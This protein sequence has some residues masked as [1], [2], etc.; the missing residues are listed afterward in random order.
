MPDHHNYPGW[1]GYDMHADMELKKHGNAVF[2]LL[3]ELC[4]LP[5]REARGFAVTTCEEV[6]GVLPIGDGPN[7]LSDEEVRE[8]VPVLQAVRTSLMVLK[9]LKAQSA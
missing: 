7:K 2:E 8:L 4:N 6:F 3:M 9:S 1:P 5:P